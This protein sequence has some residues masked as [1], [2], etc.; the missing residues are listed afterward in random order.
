MEGYGTRL[1]SAARAL[2]T[3]SPLATLDRGYAIAYSADGRILT[4]AAEASP[5][6]RLKLTLARGALETEVLEVAPAGPDI[7]E[8]GDDGNDTGP[9][10]G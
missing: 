5:G 7:G 2:H 4:D 9:D 1:T 8:D 6:D 10:A 3:V